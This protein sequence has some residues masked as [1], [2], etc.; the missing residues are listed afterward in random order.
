MVPD[1]RALR[2]RIY[3]WILERG[4]PPTSTE[5]ARSFDATPEEIKRTLAS[6]KVG[7]TVLLAPSTGEI[8]MAGPFSAVETP[9]RVRGAGAR[10]FAN[11]A[12]DM[13]GVAV[14]VNEPVQI[15]ARCT[16]CAAP[17]SLPAEPGRAPTHPGVVHFLVPARRW[18]DDIAFT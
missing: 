10:W 8:W 4:S 6:L 1:D 11:C 2:V 14:L 12:W 17:I 3:E 13:L 16:D 15:D 5:L 9:Y 18:Y 7:K